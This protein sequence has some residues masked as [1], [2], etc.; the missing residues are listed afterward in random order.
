[1]ARWAILEQ[2]LPLYWSWSSKGVKLQQ[3]SHNPAGLQ[4]PVLLTPGV[5]I[6]MF[7]SFEQVAA[8]C[9]SG[10]DTDEH[11]LIGLIDFVLETNFNASKVL[12]LIDLSGFVSRLLKPIEN[13]V[14]AEE[15]IV[16]QYP[17]FAEG[18]LKLLDYQRRKKK[19]YFDVIFSNYTKGLGGNIETDSVDGDLDEGDTKGGYSLRL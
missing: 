18:C 4:N 16:S 9:G 12:R 3:S 1:M 7:D 15:R 13:G 2:Q 19:V 10:I 17:Q 8:I 14:N 6:T 11:R 5:F